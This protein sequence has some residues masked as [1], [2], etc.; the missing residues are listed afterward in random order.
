MSQ[1]LKEVYLLNK[2]FNKVNTQKQ[3]HLLKTREEKTDIC[4]YQ[5]GKISV[6][7]QRGR[8]MVKF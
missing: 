8:R 7:R 5:F 1:T 3:I 6:E 4:F 2:L